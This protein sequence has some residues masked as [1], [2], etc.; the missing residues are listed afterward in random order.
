MARQQKRK[1]TRYQKCFRFQGQRYTVYGDTVT[2]AEQAKADKIKELEEGV[3]DRE[4]PTLNRYYERF[5]AARMDSV[6]GATI[7]G[8]SNQFRKCAAVPVINNKTFGEL[9]IREV[10]AADL[11]IVQQAIKDS[12]NSTRTVNDAMAHLNHVFNS[13][14]KDE[15][16]DRNP[17]ISISKVRRTEPPARDTVH[18]ALTKE[19]TQKFLEAAADSYFINLFKLMLN[20]G[21]RVGEAGALRAADIGNGYININKTVTRS[22]D[23]SYC[24][25]DSPK[26]S[27]S[28]RAIPLNNEGDIE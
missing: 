13:A 4:N 12:G 9:R 27:D 8:Q 7:R 28:N 2:A 17:C 18:R 20:T 16:I 26:T 15:L 6:K 24:I 22:A 3:I 5:T 19:E 23:G 1:D 14:V 21:M 11:R 10:K 25:G